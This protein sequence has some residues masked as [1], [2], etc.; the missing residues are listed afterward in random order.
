MFN[1]WKIYTK[2]RVMELTKKERR[3]INGK[4]FLS[5]LTPSFI[6]RLLSK[7]YF[8]NRNLEDIAENLNKEIANL[9]NENLV[10]NVKLQ[11][12][13]DEKLALRKALGESEERR[14]A[15]AGELDNLKD[16]FE[17]TKNNYVEDLKEIRRIIAE[18]VDRKKHDEIVGEQDDIIDR[19][20]QLNKVL[21]HKI[22]A[23]IAFAQDQEKMLQE[24]GYDLSYD[25]SKYKET[26]EI[27]K[28]I[29]K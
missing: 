12:M 27:V 25:L 17:Q 19:Q 14:V 26:Q 11:K 18:K 20:E 10:F 15:L 28:D 23:I 9:D 13:S 6:K 22:V 29:L 7:L 16:L 24:L 1:V 4:W 21:Y 8:F 5:F 3:A 2:E